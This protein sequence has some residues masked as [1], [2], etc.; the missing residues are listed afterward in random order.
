MSDTDNFL[1]HYGVKGM[2]W[3]KR[4][5]ERQA[6][7]ESTQSKDH[8]KVSGLKK[9]RVDEMSNAELEA[10]NK[11]MNLEQ[12][13]SR[14]NPKKTSAGSKFAQDIVREI[15]KEQVKTLA[16]KGLAQAGKAVVDYLVKK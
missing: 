12:Q 10:L 4:R 5:A 7:R 14:L 9:K 11:R 3:G 2:K 6:E 8:K 16:K 15:A 1:A 13:Y